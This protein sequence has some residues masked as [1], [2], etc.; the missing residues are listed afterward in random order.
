MAIEL[1]KLNALAVKNAKERG[2]LADGGGLYLQISA[3]GSKSWVFRY[4]DGGRLREMGLGPTHTLSLADARDAAL[5]CRKQRIN[6]LDPIAACLTARAAARL[7]AARAV[8][9]EQCAESY[10]ESH[11]ASWQNAKHAAQWGSTLKTYAYPVLGK[12]AVAGIDTGLV[13]KAVEP[14]WSTKSETASRL[15]QRIEAVLDWAKVRGYR[16]GENPARWKGHLDHSLPSRAKVA[17]VEHHA[18]LPYAEIGPFMTSL[19]AQPG[20]A[21]RALEFAILTAARTGEVL[22]AKWMEVDLDARMWTVPAERMK[23]KKEHRIPLSDRAIAILLS[24]KER[25]AADFVFPGGKVNKS[26]SGM[27]LLMALRRMKRDDLTAHGFRSTFRDWAAE[28]TSFPR[29]VCEH[30][31]AHSLPDKV[32]AA[33]RRGDLFD[34]R[35]GLMDAWGAYCTPVCAIDWSSDAPGERA[36]GR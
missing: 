28:Q 30:A 26:L 15:R 16:E 4:R 10:I 1:N 33:Y 25:S 23:A 21:A 5:F 9:F 36:E 6:G 17:K 32:E 24:L 22:G 7:E 3:G 18:A 27:A 35:K 14:I 29:E 19:Q 12:V 11:K 13:L 20:T 2:Y 8:T 31:L 34:K